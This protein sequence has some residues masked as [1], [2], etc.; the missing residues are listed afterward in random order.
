MSIAV[1][2]STAITVLWGMVP[3]RYQNGNITG[4]SV[5]YEVKGQSIQTI[6]VPRGDIF[7]TTISSLAL[8]TSTYSIQVA[9]VNSAGTGIYSDPLVV[10]FPRS[11]SIHKAEK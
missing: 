3:C 7:K 5:R 6:N 2:N 10:Q 11:K 9:A 1:V 8:S 4:Y